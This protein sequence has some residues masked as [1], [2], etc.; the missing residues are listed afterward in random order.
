M[1]RSVYF[2]S[3]MAAVQLALMHGQF[4]REGGPHPSGLI[5]FTL[6]IIL[7]GFGCCSWERR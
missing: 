4:V 2:T 6:V 1:N 3:M 7:I 5:N